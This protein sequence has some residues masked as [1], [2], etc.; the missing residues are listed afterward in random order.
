MV[1]VL[2]LESLVLDPM[3]PSGRVTIVV[4]VVARIASY[5]QLVIYHACCCYG[6]DEH[7][8]MIY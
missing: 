1:V 3:D 2:E 6:N 7:P 5:F 8:M 4:V